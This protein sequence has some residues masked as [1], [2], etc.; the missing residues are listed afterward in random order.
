MLVCQIYDCCQGKVLVLTAY[1]LSEKPFL[2]GLII[3]WNQRDNNEVT[4]ER[5]RW[6]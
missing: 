5:N 4:G 2:R 6:L 1:K 3:S